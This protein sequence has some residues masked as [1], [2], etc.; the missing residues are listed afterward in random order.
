MIPKSKVHALV[1]SIKMAAGGG[2]P[3]KLEYLSNLN[4]D[5]DPSN[6]L[7]G[8]QSSADAYSPSGGLSSKDIFAYTTELKQIPTNIVTALVAPVEEVMGDVSSYTAAL[9]AIPNNIISAITSTVIQ[10][11]AEIMDYL[12]SLNKI[13]TDVDTSITASTEQVTGDVNAYT[14][15][16]QGVPTDVGTSF[17][18]STENATSNVNNY[19]SILTRIPRNVVTSFIS[20]IKSVMA[21]TGI[22]VNKLNE[23]PKVVN[24]DVMVAVKAG[25]ASVNSFIHSLNKIPRKIITVLSTVQGK[26]GG[27]LIAPIRMAF[28]GGVPGSGT[29]DTVPTMLESGEFVEPKSVVK[30]Y[31]IDLFEALRAKLIPKGS[32]QSLLSN[33]K[34]QTGGVVSSFRRASIPVIQRMQAGGE[35]QSKGNLYTIKFAIG[36]ES[37]QLYGEEDSINSLVNNL[38]RSQLVTV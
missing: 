31:G 27:G 19:D 28:G 33:L 3:T 25:M 2:V 34:M 29:G 17:T 35:V 26:Q 13:P 37:H 20:P 15:E 9:K 5:I 16:L 32:V 14:D 10:S 22:Y 30:E 18:A 24:T 11:T 21:S 1:P 6:L 7:T 12:K 38:R 23:I 36:N 4:P 8:G